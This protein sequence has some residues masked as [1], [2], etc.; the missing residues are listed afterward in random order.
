MDWTM[1]V[2]DGATWHDGDAVDG[3]G[4]GV[5]VRGSSPTTSMP[6]YKD[7]FP[8]DPTFEVVATTSCIWHAEEPTFAPEI[9]AYVPIV[10]E[11]HLGGVQRGGR[12]ERHPQRPPRSSRTRTR[13]A[14]ARS[15]SS[16]YA[17]GQCM[18]I[19]AL[20]PTT[21]A[22][23]PPARRSRSSRLRQPGERWCSDLK[24]RA[25]STSSD[26]LNATLFNCLEGSAEHRPTHVGDGGCWGNFAWNFG[27]QGAAG[28]APIPAIHDLAFRQAMAHA[29]DRQEIVDKVYQGTSTLGYSVLMP[30]VNG[31]WYSD[32]PP[33]L[34]FNYDP[35]Q[36][37]TM[38]DERRH[39]RHQR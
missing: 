6:F 27:G 12:P 38:L 33:E 5:L 31:S 36:A 15:S 34:Q 16:E 21:G 32:I 17:K 3:R 13:S 25:S 29:I 8:F 28:H 4:R 30:G 39:H 20:T 11:A 9:P 35:E 14:P 18:R 2:R 1:N 10:P 37:N 26:G 7:Y 22:G 24:G 19:G 23:S